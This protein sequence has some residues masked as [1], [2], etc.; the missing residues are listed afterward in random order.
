MDIHAGQF[1]RIPDDGSDTDGQGSSNDE[2]GIHCTS[3]GAQEQTGYQVTLI[4]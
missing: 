1:I 4:L 2:E 3:P